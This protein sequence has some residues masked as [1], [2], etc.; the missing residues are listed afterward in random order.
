MA[1]KTFTT[2]GFG[3]KFT[4][5]PKPIM[6]P[7]GQFNVTKIGGRPRTLYQHLILYSWPKFLIIVLFFYLSINAL[8]A[9]TYQL[10]GIEHLS[11][12]P[13]GTVYTNY[14]Y[15]FFFSIQTFTTVG[16]GAIAPIGIGANIVATI[17]AVSGILAFALVTGMLYGR[18]ATPNTRLRFS[19]NVLVVPTEGGKELHF[20]FVNER[21]EMLL[22][23]EI[24]VLVKL[25]EKTANTY[26]RRFYELPLR[27]NKIVFFPLN[28]RVVHVIDENSPLFEMTQGE[29]LE[30]EVELLILVQA[31][32]N[33]FRQT[34][35]A[36]SEYTSTNFLFNARFLPAYGSDNTGQ[37]IM[38][39]DDI[40][41]FE[42]V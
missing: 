38:N 6:G 7:D 9:L 35:Y 15:C 37:T 40:D 32:D 19:K 3:E 34:V 31:Y 5:D 33:V 8:F 42:L 17:E 27:I 13:R 4:S 24:Q 23:P 29:L 26:V 39:L 18:F 10:V 1:K 20:Q 41:K 2:S 12:I 11:G 16:Y 22:H 21:Q 30:K 28:W 14:L 36:W 25:N